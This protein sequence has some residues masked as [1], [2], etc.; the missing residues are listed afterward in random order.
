[1]ADPNSALYR[2]Q[3]QIKEA[4]ENGNKDT[5]LL[6]WY[7]LG[8]LYISMGKYS[9]SI[10][11]HQKMVGIAKGLGLNIQEGRAYYGIARANCMLNNIVQAIEYCHKC[12]TTL[13]GEKDDRIV[14]IAC[15]D[16]SAHYFTV[17]NIAKSMEY[18]QKSLELAEK[19]EDKYIEMLSYFNLG[20][21]NMALRN[22]EKA[23]FHYKRALAIAQER[24]DLKFAEKT[25]SYLGDV[26]TLF[27]KP[28]EALQHHKQT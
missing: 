20:K 14:R 4:Q 5:E 25:A 22:Y 21:S 11:C 2:C 23:I 10:E 27:E 19:V 15:C 18:S 13:E 16:L 7:K 8:T 6:A 17:R 9:E 12:I 26:Y 3:Q 24:T 1:M 28:N